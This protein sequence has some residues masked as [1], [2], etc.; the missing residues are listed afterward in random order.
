MDTLKRFLV[1]EDAMGTVEVI[2]IT[3]VLVGI[4]IMF[5]GRIVNYAEAL[6]DGITEQKITVGDIAND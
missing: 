3:A 6:L 2:L 1:E 4:G 5:K